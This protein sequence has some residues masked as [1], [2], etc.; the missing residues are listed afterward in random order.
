MKHIWPVQAFSTL[1][2]KGLSQTQSPFPST[3]VIYIYICKRDS[4]S[5]QAFGNTC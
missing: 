3:F 2:Q 4:E 1:N 5:L